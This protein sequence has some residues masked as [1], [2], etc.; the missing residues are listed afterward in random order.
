MAAEAVKHKRDSWQTWENYAQVAVRVQ[1]WQTAV[2]A[3]QQVLVQSEGQRVDLGVLAALVGQVEAGRGS[4]PGSE[5]AVNAAEQAAARDSSDAAAAAEADSPADP[6]VSAAA[7]SSGAGMADLVA[8]FG[9]LNGRGEQEG[10]TSGG[11]G[12]GSATAAAE[13]ADALQKADAR[14]QAMLEQAVGNLLKQ[15]AATVS[16]ASAFWEVYAR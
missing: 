15:V 16:G 2:R 3:L 8:A 11:A 13:A 5:A 12:G 14:S 6:A 4:G 9:E 1:Q 7:E 10:A